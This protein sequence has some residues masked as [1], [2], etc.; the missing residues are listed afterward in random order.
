[1]ASSLSGLPQQAAISA[2]FSKEPVTTA[3]RAS[4]WVSTG[5]KR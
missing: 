1:M 2:A 5:L 3:W 4:R